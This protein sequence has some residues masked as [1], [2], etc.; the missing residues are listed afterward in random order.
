MIY[1]P[2]SLLYQAVTLH[3]SPVTI[4]HSL[5]PLCISPSYEVQSDFQGGVCW[6]SVVNK[7]LE[8]QPQSW[9]VAEASGH[10]G[11]SGVRARLG[12]ISEYSLTLTSD[13]QVPAP[14]L[15]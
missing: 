4:F 11:N 7:D 12:Q 13:F 10:R 2:L 14:L 15:R 8:R 1:Q 9:L 3:H 5:L 6:P